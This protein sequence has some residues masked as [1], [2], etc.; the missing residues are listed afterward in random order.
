M[1]LGGTNALDTDNTST[2]ARQRIYNVGQDILFA[3]SN[4]KKLTS[5]HVGLGLTLHQAT[6]SEKLVDLFNSA[7]ATIGIDTIRRLDTTIAN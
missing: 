5:K 6:R 2:D 1:L 7:G 4:G 3:I